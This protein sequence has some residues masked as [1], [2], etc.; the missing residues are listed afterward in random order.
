[1][2]SAGDRRAGAVKIGVS[3]YELTGMK[4]RHERPCVSQGD[5]Q[6]ARRGIEKVYDLFTRIA[7]YTD[8]TGTSALVA[9]AQSSQFT[10]GR[11]NCQ[12]RGNDRVSTHVTL[13][14]CDVPASRY[15]RAHLAGLGKLRNA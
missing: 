7:S 5:E 12:E 13:P 11:G 2:R 10:P 3:H 4:M 15:V 8:N 1:M 9:A 6:T 14:A